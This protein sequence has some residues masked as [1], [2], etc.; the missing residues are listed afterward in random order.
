ME[1]S[2]NK[3]DYYYTYNYSTDNRNNIN[4]TI[5]QEPKRK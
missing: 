1:N 3:K 4:C 5:S 2:R